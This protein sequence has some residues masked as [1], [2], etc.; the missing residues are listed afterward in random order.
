[1]NEQSLKIRRAPA[2]AGRRGEQGFSLVE[3]LVAMTILS[4]GLLGMAALTVG[5]MHGN[6]QSKNVTEATALAT[7]RL[8]FLRNRGFGQVPAGTVITTEGYGSI[9]GFPEYRRV[10]QTQMDT[11]VA[12]AA[13]IQVSVF[14]KLDARSVVLSTIVSG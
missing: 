14:W 4:I 11:P 12:G 5:I 3:I 1:M 9:A 10:T 7:D 13:R 2:F 8:E 6:T